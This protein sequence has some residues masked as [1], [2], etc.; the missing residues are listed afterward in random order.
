MSSTLSAREIYVDASATGA[1]NGTN[2]ADAYTNMRD[3]VA[4]ANGASMADNIHVSAG[5]YV[6]LSP[7]MITEPC[8]VR[9]HGSGAVIF[10]SLALAAPIFRIDRTDIHFFDVEFNLSAT[11]VYGYQSGVRF[12]RC[13]FTL[14]S[15]SSVVGDRCHLMQ[16]KYCKFYKNSSP[17]PGGAILS[18]DSRLVAI[19]D[20][21]FS[22]NNSLGSGGA[23][24][25][26]STF[27]TGNFELH[28]TRFTDNHAASDGGGLSLSNTNATLIN[29]VLLFN[30]AFQGGAIAF[31]NVAGYSTLRLI[32]STVFRNQAINT[33]GIS[34][35]SSFFGI[36]HCRVANS[37]VYSNASAAAPTL[38]QQFN[39]PPNRIS[40]SCVAGW[41]SLPWPGFA[42]IASPP[43]LLPSGRPTAL[44]PC[45]DTGNARFC[46][47]PY[48]ITGSPRVIGPNIDM[49]AYER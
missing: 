4:D 44:S 49:G 7:Y 3:A 12:D 5:H 9:G 14:A 15:L 23:V 40:H 30:R 16:F 48:D 45:I 26:T 36:T 28:N 29:N 43:A 1:A 20:S 27:P 2:W 13:E 34:C 25:G 32:N 35:S 10:E 24:H 6:S 8:T 31:Q 33:G 22:K 38:L 17:G 21:E 39:Q 19:H 47:L 18:N 41:G 46:P 42:V 11:H 37:I